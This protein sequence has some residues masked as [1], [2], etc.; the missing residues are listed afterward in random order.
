ML[1]SIRIWN[2]VPY[3]GRLKTE[4]W[5]YWISTYIHIVLYNSTNPKWLNEKDVQEKRFNIPKHKAILLQ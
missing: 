5:Q 2:I 4:R 3:S 1:Y